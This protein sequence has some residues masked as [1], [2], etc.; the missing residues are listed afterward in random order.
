LISTRLGGAIVGRVVQATAAASV[1]A[2]GQSY[3][4]NGSDHALFAQLAERDHAVYVPILDSQLVVVGFG[5]AQ[6]PQGVV[7]ST[8][9]VQR[10]FDP[11]PAPANQRTPRVAAGNAASTLALAIPVGVNVSQLLSDHSAIAD[12]LLAPALRR[13]SETQP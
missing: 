10:P 3:P 1:L 2:I 12:P 11:A 7:R 4:I 8:L 9:V 13:S 5:Y 6:W